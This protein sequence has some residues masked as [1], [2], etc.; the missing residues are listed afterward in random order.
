MAQA[1]YRGFTLTSKG[2]DGWHVKIR[3]HDLTGSKQALQKTIDWF[4]DSKVLIKPEQ[5][6]G[7]GAAKSEQP[8]RQVVEYK[9][10]KLTNDTGKANEWYCIF[11]G[12]LVQ[13]SQP[14]LQAQIDKYHALLEAQQRK[15]KS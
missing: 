4:I 3:Q 10:F 6:E 1:T 7:V 2:N 11:R 9:Q 12:R 8:K 15:S 13:G 14:A 5:F